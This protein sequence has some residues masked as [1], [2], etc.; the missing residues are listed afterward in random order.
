M[1]S[2]AAKCMLGFAFRLMLL[3]WLSANLLQLNC[4]DASRLY[5]LCRGTESQLIDR[6][7]DCALCVYTKYRTLFKRGLVPLDFWRC[8]PAEGSSWVI[9]PRYRKPGVSAGHLHARW[10]CVKFCMHVCVFASAL[11]NN[12]MQNVIML[13]CCHMKAGRVCCFQLAKASMK[14]HVCSF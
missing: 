8:P 3:P 11:C 2:A 7:L 12:R 10:D 14:G 4:F 5:Y 1:L 9:M 6:F 13:R